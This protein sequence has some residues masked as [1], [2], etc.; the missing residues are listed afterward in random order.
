[1][2]LARRGCGRGIRLARGSELGTEWGVWRVCVWSSFECN[3]LLTARLGLALAA[4]TQR[5]AEADVDVVCVCVV[6][7][8]VLVLITKPKNST[9]KNTHTHW[10]THTQTDRHRHRQSVA[11]TR[12]VRG[13]QR[14]PKILQTTKS[15]HETSVARRQATQRG[16]GSGQGAW[17]SGRNGTD[18]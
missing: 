8:P 6:C 4:E 13:R 5:E 2:Q 11:H 15:F 17:Q 9:P 12:H 10:Y 1:M 16:G 7:A 3:A 18:D 14:A